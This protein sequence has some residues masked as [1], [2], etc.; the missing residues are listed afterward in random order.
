[1]PVRSRWPHEAYDFTPWLAKSENLDLLG[2]EL[3]LSLSKVKTEKP[4]GPYFLDILAEET[5]TGALVA[6]EN[7]LAWTNIHH[8]GQLLTYT[9]GCDT[10]IAIWV[11]PEF[12]YEHAQALDWLNQWTTDEVGFYGVKVESI[13]QAA[14]SEPEARFRKVVWP[15]GWNKGGCAISWDLGVLA[16]VGVMLQGVRGLRSW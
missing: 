1:M 8:L 11:A 14:D 6:I 4:V 15:G 16:G 13:R 2:E 7:Q 3:G 12:R 5:A 9:A 10:R